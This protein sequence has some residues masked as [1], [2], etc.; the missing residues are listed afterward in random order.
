[1]DKGR[2]EDHNR[3]RTR[4]LVEM[5]SIMVV[6]SAFH[7]LMVLP[8]IIT[9]NDKLY[10]HVCNSGFLSPA[11]NVWRRHDLLERT[12]GVLP[13]EQLSHNNLT[14]LYYM[15]VGLVPTLSLMEILLYCLYQ[16]KV[17][18]MDFYQ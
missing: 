5:V 11:K 18:N 17:N 6:R 9:G 4:I 7:A 16:Y 1:M 8:V 2:I 12:I 13:E 3:R 15:A 14:I 10:H